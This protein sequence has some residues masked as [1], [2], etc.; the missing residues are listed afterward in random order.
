MKQ[1]MAI[2]LA[3]RFQAALVNLNVAPQLVAK[4]ERQ[5]RQN[6]T[7]SSCLKVKIKKFSQHCSFETV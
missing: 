5:N 6:K 1:V 4:Q 7:F 3:G 2:R